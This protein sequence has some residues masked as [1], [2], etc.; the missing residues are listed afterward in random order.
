MLHYAYTDVAQFAEAMDHY[1]RLSAQHYFETG[2]SWWQ[3]SR[4]AEVVKPA[5]TFFYRQLVRGGIF[6]GPLCLQLNIIYA[7]YV[8]KKVK[9]L[10][11]LT[12]A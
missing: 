5:W 3:A 7:G 6:L 9:Y 4:L 1:S 8:R 10:R 12:A 11:E 2:H